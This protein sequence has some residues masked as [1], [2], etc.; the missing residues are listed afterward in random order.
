MLNGVRVP[1]NCTVTSHMTG[2]TANAA[3]DVRCE[4]TLFRTVILAVTNPAAVLA[5]LVFVIAERAVQRGEFTKLVA[6]VIVLA[7]RRRSS[8]AKQISLNSGVRAEWN[9]PSR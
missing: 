6:L 4:V 8:L 1:V 5:Y 3:D 2:T 7:F 9:S